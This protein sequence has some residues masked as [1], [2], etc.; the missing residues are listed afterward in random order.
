MKEIKKAKSAKYRNERK[1]K[2]K[3]KNEKRK[4]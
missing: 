1:N 2:E 4:N 3:A